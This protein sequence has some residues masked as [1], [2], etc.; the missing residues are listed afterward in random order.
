M[1]MLVIL[2]PFWVFASSLQH[3]QVQTSTNMP[4]QSGIQADWDSIK[5]AGICAEDG[6]DCLVVNMRQI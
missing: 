2:W 5:D 6:T 1:Q 3:V 4:A